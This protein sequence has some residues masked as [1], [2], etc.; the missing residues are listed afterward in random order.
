M[1]YKEG[2]ISAA[3]RSLKFKIQLERSSG[4]IPWERVIY[5]K[6]ENPLLFFLGKESL[7]AIVGSKRPTNLEKYFIRMKGNRR[8]SLAS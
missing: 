1:F 8:Q 6:K 2:E 4:P 7:V 5:I 3:I